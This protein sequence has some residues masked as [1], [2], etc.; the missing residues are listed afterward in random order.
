MNNGVSQL[1]VLCALIIVQ[2]GCAGH[3]APSR[4]I[5]SARDMPDPTTNHECLGSTCG[6]ATLESQWALGNMQAFRYIPEV[7]VSLECLGTVCGGQALAPTWVLETSS[8]C[9]STVCGPQSMPVIHETRHPRV[10]SNR[11]DQRTSH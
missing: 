10:A 11:F 7:R 1:I 9:L 5:K 6:T 4:Q 8:L 2:A 3:T